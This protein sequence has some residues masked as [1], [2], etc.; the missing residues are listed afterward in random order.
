MPIPLTDTFSK[1][2][3]SRN[4]R[5]KQRGGVLAVT[6]YLDRPPGRARKKA[7]TRDAAGH[8]CSS[9]GAPRDCDDRRAPAFLRSPRAHHM[10]KYS[11]A[12][13]AAGVNQPSATMARQGR[14]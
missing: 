10:I 6:D 5:G 12:L 7:E 2:T 13:H 1:S 14:E 8:R 4:L 9:V 11:S 3:G